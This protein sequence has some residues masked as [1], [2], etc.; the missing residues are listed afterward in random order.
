MIV[1]GAYNLLGPGVNADL[2]VNNAEPLLIRDS[3]VL[4]ISFLWYQ[5]LILYKMKNGTACV[6]LQ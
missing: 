5:Q 4:N 3:T 6:L 1:C 2:D